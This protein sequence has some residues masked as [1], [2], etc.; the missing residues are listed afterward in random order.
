[1]SISWDESRIF[2]VGCTF[3][4][5]S[6]LIKFGSGQ[7]LHKCSAQFICTIFRRPASGMVNLAFLLRGWGLERGPTPTRVIIMFLYLFLNMCMCKCY[8]YIVG[9]ELDQ[10][11]SLK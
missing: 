10:G 5:L 11:Y 6:L 3:G 1:M 2:K 8:K 4:V 7:V 9:A